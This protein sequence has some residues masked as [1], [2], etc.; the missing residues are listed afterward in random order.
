MLIY[1]VQIGNVNV[2]AMGAKDPKKPGFLQIYTD[3]SALGNG[4]KGSIAGVGV[5]FGPNDKRNVSE[6]LATTSEEQTNQRAELTAA[7]RALEITPLNKSVQIY[8]DSKYTIDCVTNWYKGWEKRA[9]D[10]EKKSGKKEE[11]MNA[12]GQP[13]KNADLI[14]A[15]RAKME[16][17]EKKGTETDFVWVKG[18]AGDPNHT[19]NDAADR[20]AVAGAQKALAE[21]TASAVS[22]KK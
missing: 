14:R 6:A 11:W 12:Q 1:S 2:F 8:T 16:E 3:G 4:K 7:K 22:K 21:R 10:A 15:I 9:R 20:L 18:H 5:F 13:V 19:G 17:R